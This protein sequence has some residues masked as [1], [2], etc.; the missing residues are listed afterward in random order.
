MAEP[1]E[2][3]KSPKSQT[4]LRQQPLRQLDNSHKSSGLVLYK[5]GNLGTETQRGEDAPRGEISNWREGSAGPWAQARLGSPLLGG[6]QEG[7][8]PGAS[9]GSRIPQTLISDFWSAELGDDACLL[10]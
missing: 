3:M 10:C 6:G 7:P 5:T 4:Q 9:G 2:S 1:G 8:S